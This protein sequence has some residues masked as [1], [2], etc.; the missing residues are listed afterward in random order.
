MAVTNAI[1]D[2][3]KSVYELLASILGAAY[4]IIH[5]FI[6]G[7]LGLFAGFFAFVGDIGKGVFDLVGGVGKFIAGNAVILAVIGAAGYAYIRFVQQPQQQQGRRPVTAGT[8]GVK[9]TN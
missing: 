7:V 6:N 1:T 5:S 4:T 2:L 9:K 3:V 8:G